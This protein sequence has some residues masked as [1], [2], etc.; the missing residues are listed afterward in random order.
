MTD[1]AHQKCINPDCA[2]TYAVDEVKVLIPSRSVAAGCEIRL[3]S[4][5]R[6][7]EHGVFRASLEHQGVGS[8]RAAGFF[9]SRRF[10]EL[11]PF[12]RK[13]EDVVTIGEGRTTLQVAV[14][15]AS[16]WT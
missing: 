3:G 14:P 8:R 13:E 15:W 12:F 1:R 4:A 10:C 7:Q 2:A 5:A 6:P 16:R 9:G 11:M